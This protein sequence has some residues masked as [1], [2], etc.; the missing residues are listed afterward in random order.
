MKSIYTYNRLL[1][2]LAMLLSL[3]GVEAQEA[4]ALPRL[5]VNVMID[6]LR[7]DYMEAF[8]PLYGDRGFRRLMQEGCV[9]TQAEYPFARPDRA[10]AT[11][12][13][14]SGATPY[15]NGIPSE[16]WLDRQSLRP[17]YCVDDDKFTGYLTAEKSSPLYL[18]VSTI[19]DEL[20]VA[21]EGKGIV[22]SVSPFRDAAILAAGH[23]ADACFWLND[24][25]GQWCSTSY[26]GDFP[27]WALSYSRYNSPAQRIDELTWVP[28]NEIV[29]NFSYF[30]SGGLKSPFSHKFNGNGA[31]RSFKASGMI[32]EEV[33]RFALYC[34]SS[35]GIGLDAVTDM[36]SLTY[37]A[38]NFNHGSVADN[39]M[40]L[41]DTYVRLDAALGQM[42]D[43]VEKRVGKGNVLFVVTGTGYCDEPVSA[44][45]SK[46]RIP[47]GNFDMQRAEMLLN[48]YLVAVYGQGQWVEGSLGNEIYLNLKL[49]E[50]RNV[51]LS[52]LLDMASAFIIQ[53][54]G[55]KDVYTS[56]RLSLGAWTPG[57]SRLRN[58]YNPHRS[59]DILVQIAPGWT[60]VGG[61]SVAHVK[62]QVV[63]RESY[64]AF[65]LFFMGV[66][67]VPCKEE[68]PV[69]IDHVAPTV[70]KVLRI[71]SPNA[72]GQAPLMR[73]E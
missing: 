26:Y 72:C 16:W 42:I 67:F 33:N 64:T 31:Y 56:Q 32:N 1:T 36:L 60:L 24:L 4:P 66:G 65:P 18:S 59:G 52:D 9:Y 7:S 15:D 38:G 61:T 30:V 3:S 46:Y 28:S 49:I 63:S 51:N 10:S 70:A 35:T 22:I 54:G 34:M 57:I 40:E 12:C 25:T 43:E 58:A 11:A 50:Q 53:L 62:K 19:G 71:R 48:M 37:Y 13:L 5:V 55:V 2:T 41:Q 45:L 68:T 14:Y 8:S 44:D 29:G 27:S 6:Q 23:A 39:P 21:T 20:K 73:T 47:S 17:I 69:T